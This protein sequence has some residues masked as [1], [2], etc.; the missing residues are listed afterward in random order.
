MWMRSE[1]R[2]GARGEDNDDRD[3]TQATGAQHPC[4]LPPDRGAA[5]NQADS[6]VRCSNNKI[7]P[8][9]FEATMRLRPVAFAL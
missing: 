4:I 3:G 7:S 8:G 9:A 1:Y 2:P 5:A 6:R